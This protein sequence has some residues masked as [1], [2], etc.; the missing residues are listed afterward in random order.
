MTQPIAFQVVDIHDSGTEVTV[1]WQGQPGAHAHPV[2][3]TVVERI[4]HQ[5]AA[6]ADAAH[7][8]GRRRDIVPGVVQA[9]APDLGPAQRALGET[10]YAMLD[11]PERAL[12]RRLGDAWARQHLPQADA[13]DAAQEAFLALVHKAAALQLQSTL[14]GYLFGLLRIQVLRAWRALHRRRGEPLEDDDAG[15]EV[16]SVG[17]RGRDHDWRALLRTCLAP[18]AQRRWLFGGRGPDPIRAAAPGEPACGRSPECH[19][20]RSPSQPASQRVAG[21]PAP[22]GAGSAPAANSAGTLVHTEAWPGHPACEDASP[23]PRNTRPP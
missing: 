11:G 17:R 7:H 13:E 16:P 21:R 22:G 4:T 9:S 12:A 6:L 3:T 1:Q 18:P 15:A 2:E 10:L 8:T 23:L 20:L 5:V 19:A 14:R